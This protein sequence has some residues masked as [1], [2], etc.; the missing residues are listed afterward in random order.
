MKTLYKIGIV[1]FAVLFTMYTGGFLVFSHHC[2][3]EQVTQTSFLIDATSCGHHENIQKSDPEP[4]CE[5]SHKKTVCDFKTSIQ[6]ENDCC[7][8]TSTF[9]KAPIV[10]IINNEKP[11]IDNQEYVATESYFYVF[12]QP[13]SYILHYPE[14]EPPPPIFGKVLLYHIHQL[15]I[16]C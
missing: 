9:V 12:E 10:V 1:F 2:F 14:I 13:S 8:T 16:Y 6:T 7:K 15:K 3:R 5:H 4:C 11:I